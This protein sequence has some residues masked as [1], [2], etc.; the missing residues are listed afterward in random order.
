MAVVC[1]DDTTIRD[2][3]A[4]CRHVK[5]EMIS[6][7]AINVG[8]RSRFHPIVQDRLD[9]DRVIDPRLKLLHC[10][11]VT[12]HLDKSES[13]AAIFKGLL[14]GIVQCRV[15]LNCRMAV[16]RR[17]KTSSFGQKALF[18]S[19]SVTSWRVYHNDLKIFIYILLL[20]KF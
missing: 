10:Q 20:K 19:L 6:F 17:P 4:T 8:Q 12:T 1:D 2:D 11:T 13:I 18:N 14:R 9:S 3:I 7:V 16:P 15:F 5:F